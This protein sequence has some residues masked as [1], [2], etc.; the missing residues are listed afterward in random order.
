MKHYIRLLVLLVAILLSTSAAFAAD[1][2]EELVCIPWYYVY[3]V[4]DDGVT[5]T[6]GDNAIFDDVNKIEVTHNMIV[7]LKTTENGV[8][9]YTAV[10][11][12]KS[13]IKALKLTERKY[14]KNYN[15]GAFTT[16][17]YQLDPTKIG[18]Y[19][20]S[21]G[22]LKKD[23]E[24]VLPGLG[25]YSKPEASLENI[26]HTTGYIE[27]SDNSFYVILQKDQYKTPSISLRAGMEETAK[28]CT[29]EQ[30]PDAEFTYKITPN[31]ADCYLYFMGGST[32]SGK[33]ES[34]AC[35]KTPGK[36]SISSVKKSANKK[37]LVKWNKAEDATGYQVAISKSKSFKS[38]VSVYNVSAS[39]AKKLIKVKKSGKYYV[40]VRA[41]HNFNNEISYGA[42]SKIKSAKA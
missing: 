39:S 33:G 19:T 5:L 17:T 23:I 41:Y 24:I 36:V 18:T 1:K 4:A 22:K 30:L 15:G 32:N 14:Q 7:A 2:N 38:G 37:I 21:Y 9:K 3:F 12:A 34:I 31:T 25:F 27:G 10:S 8:T 35:I 28:N 11:G 13:E 26:I 29:I 6:M 40:R 16:I 20:I 42:W